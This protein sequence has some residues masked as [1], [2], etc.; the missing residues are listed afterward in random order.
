MSND[1]HKF[2]CES[3]ALIFFFTSVTVLVKEVASINKQCII[4]HITYVLK[5]FWY[6]SQ[7]SRLTNGSLHSLTMFDGYI[8]NNT[9]KIIICIPAVTLQHTISLP[10]KGLDAWTASDNVDDLCFIQQGWKL[11][12]KN[13]QR[14]EGFVLYIKTHFRERGY[15][16]D[17]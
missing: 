17:F 13:V 11:L 15:R 9:T 2:V 14:T 6:K 1:K 3:V 12:R 4:C 8:S 7:C 16:L 10:M 5:M